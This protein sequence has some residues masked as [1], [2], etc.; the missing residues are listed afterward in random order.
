MTSSSEERQDQPHRRKMIKEG[1]SSAVHQ[2]QDQPH[3][4]QRIS[5]RIKDIIVGGTAGDQPHRRER[6]KVGSSSARISSMIN[7]VIDRG[8][9][10]RSRTSSSKVADISVRGAAGST[11]ST[12]EGQGRISVRRRSAAGSRTSSSEEQQ[13]QAHRRKRIRE[14]SRLHG[15]AAG[16]TTSSPEDP[17]ELL[18][19]PTEKGRSSTSAPGPT[20]PPV[21][22]DLGGIF[23]HFGPVVKGKQPEVVKGK[24]PEI[25]K[26][27]AT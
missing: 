9:T 25:G 11:T 20:T 17:A 10:A 16:S 15:P 23:S 4:R 24:Q 19:R 7:H 3:H 14:G 27:K 13:P 26:R 1:S 8:S 6:T 12:K 5:S 22:S 2:L 18:H 21:P